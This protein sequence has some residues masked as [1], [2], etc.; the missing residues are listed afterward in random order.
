MFAGVGLTKT[1]GSSDVFRDL[2]FNTSSGRALVIRGPNG[3]GKTTL[4][5]CL[6]GSER[7]DGGHVIVNE[8]PQR[9]SAMGYWSQAYGVLDD[10][11]WFPE[12]TIEDHL[13]LHD[14]E[15]DAEDALAHFGIA[16]LANRLAA[17]LSSGQLRRAALATTLVRPW[18]ILL[19]DEP[20]QRL[21]EH[22]LRQLITA[23]TAFQ[24]AGRVVVLSTHLK[25][26]Q[27]EIPSDV[28]TLSEGE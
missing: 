26:L 17:S 28:L 24:D 21:D 27:D 3:S 16:G 22:G 8:Q 4:L 15:A 25:R 9:T 18:N 11:S 23:V 2:S 14:P 10:F 12:L 20:E 6:L 19:L 1:Y 7:L 13:R 5:R